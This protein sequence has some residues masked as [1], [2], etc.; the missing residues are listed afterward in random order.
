VDG[1]G[2]EGRNQTEVTTLMSRAC[3]PFGPSSDLKPTSQKLLMTD[4]LPP[5]H[6]LARDSEGAGGVL[7]AEPVKPP[8]TEGPG[9]EPNP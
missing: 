7:P 5:F 1:A 6:S 8:L 9:G 4:V 3:G 2:D